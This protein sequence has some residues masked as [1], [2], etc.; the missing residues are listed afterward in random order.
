MSVRTMTVDNKKCDS[1]SQRF[2]PECVRNTFCFLFL[3]SKLIN[4]SV[5]V[6]F[7]FFFPHACV[8]VRHHTIIFI[9]GDLYGT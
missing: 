8:S 6:W 1:G 5:C 9:H 4:V 7:F 2:K 3:I